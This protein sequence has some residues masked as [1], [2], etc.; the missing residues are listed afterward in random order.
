MVQK[1]GYIST[2]LL[3]L[4][5]CSFGLFVVFQSIHAYTINTYRDLITDS[6]PNERSNHTVEFTTQVAIPPGGYIRFLLEDSAFTI[7]VSTT[8]FSLDNVEL[9]VDPAGGGY[10]ERTLADTASAVT[11]GVSITR[12]SSSPQV[13]FTLNSTTG[14]PAGGRVKILLGTHTQNAS[15]TEDEGILNPSATGTFRFGIEAGG[16]G[17]DES[18]PG[19][20]VI[21]DNVSVGPIDTTETIPP[22]RFDGA[23][24]G[25]LSGTTQNVEMSLE[26]DEFAICRYATVPG[27][28]YFSMTQEFETTFTTV[29]AVVV[30]VVASTTYSFYVRCIDDEGNNNIDDYIISFSILPE[31]VGNP[32]TE[33]EV[34]GEGTG[35]GDGAGNANPGDGDPQGTDDTSG[36]SVQG[37]GSGGGSGGGT[38]PSSGGSDGGG[39]FEGSGAPY[40]SGE[41]RVFINGYAFPRSTVTILVDGTRALDVTA[42]T[43]GDFSAT[44]EDIARGVYTFGVYATDRNGIRSSTFSTTFTVTGS[45]SSSLSNVNIMPSIEVE[46]DP[47]DP[48]EVVRFSGYAIPDATITIEN[49]NDRT[50]ASLKTFTTTSNGNG[51]WSF[52][53]DTTGF[54]TGTYK[55]RAKA[56]QTGGV[57]TNFSEFTYY[58]V[59]EEAEGPRTTDLNRD[60]SVNLIDFSILLFWWNSDGGNSNPPADINAD[61]RVS[62][63]DFSIMIFN[64]T[65]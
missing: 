24:T 33:G 19:F 7:P 14:V 59:G 45:R 56:L 62:L 53:T 63:T 36:G 12:G 61:G 43:D 39:G 2:L 17:N 23:P 51:Q 46:P 15:T 1:P 41:G 65:G 38:G 32:G 4:L 29:H 3:T 10:V 6:A 16:G 20:V 54:T 26:T 55:V 5:C 35:T 8:T 57:S 47:V 60:G 34:E 21:L 48:G 58:G 31:P 11:D 64:W 13:E 37:G 22:V 42:S 44:V 49:Q 9:H 52:E 27:V 25:T 28:N 18:V 30:P 40:Q 50:S